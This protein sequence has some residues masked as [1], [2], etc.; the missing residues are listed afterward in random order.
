MKTKSRQRKYWTP[1]LHPKIICHRP[2]PKP[3]RKLSHHELR[4]PPP[5]RPE[6][7]ATKQT[8][9]LPHHAG[10]H[11][12][13]GLGHRHGGHW[14]GL[15]TKHP[16]TTLRHGL[17]YDHHPPEQQCH[18]RR[19]L[20]ATNVQTL[21]LDDV[22]ALQKQAPDLSAVS[23]MANARG[24]AIYGNNNWPTTMQGVQPNYLS[25]IRQW[26][27]QDGTSFTDRDVQTQSKVCLLGQT[28]IGN[29]FPNGGSPVGKYI[30]FGNVPLL[31]IGT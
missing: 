16:A 8:A 12:R 13:R 9:G 6:G 20:D 10:H 22:K 15:Q 26:P 4:Q 23:P 29:L 2:R 25:I 3:R 14:S 28:V 1:C 24:Q 7:A 19:R 5:D 27:V 17:Q 31:V 18:R 30:R 11:H 21:T